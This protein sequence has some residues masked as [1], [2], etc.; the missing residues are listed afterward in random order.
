MRF[1]TPTFLAFALLAVSVQARSIDKRQSSVANW[2]ANEEPIA[3]SALF[4]NI[5]PGGEFSKGVDAGAVIASPSTAS[6]DYYYQWTRDG[7]LVFKVLLNEYING[8]TTLETFLKAYASESDKLQKT[9][10]PSGG[11]STGGIGE[12]KFMVNGAAFTGSWG[13]PQ[14]DGPAI[15]A[16]V[17]TK[18]ANML[19]DAGQSSYVSGLLY[20]SA[21]PATTVIKSDLEYVAHNWQTQGFDLW[22]EVNSNLHFFNM[23]VQQ[24]ALREGAAL[25]TR[26]NDGGAATYYTQQ[27]NAIRAR[28]PEFWSSSKGYLVSTLQTSRDGLDCG[29][30]LGALHGNGAAGQGIYQAS[31]DEVLVTLQALVNAFKPLY[32][33]N[34]ASGSP[35]T[36]IG[37][38]TSDVYDGVGTSVAHPWFI[39]TFT[40]AEVLLTAV[41]EFN[42]KGSIAVSSLSVNFYKQFYSSAAAGSTYALGSTGFNS[43][44]NGMKNY[45][46]TFLA[47]T[48]RHAMTNGSLSEQ[49]SRNDGYQK[50]ARDL[51][52]SYASFLTTRWAREGTVAF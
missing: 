3:R 9:N 39:C 35:G 34:T 45:A 11:Y 6:P 16:T 27:A 19:L 21:Y 40:V 5:G 15:R 12:P 52:W 44:V 46:D 37:R 38:Y 49:F 32:P 43:I 14:T 10:N 31:S 7:A 25:A 2:V 24:R 13:R 48:Q 33:I 22:E 47:V 29:T 51:T 1:H 8:N 18:F 26:L 41:S 23:M 28:L 42:K 4:R 17:L 36:A 50:G 20:S 30:L